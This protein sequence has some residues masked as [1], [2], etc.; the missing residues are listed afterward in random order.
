MGRVFSM[1]GNVIELAEDGLRF[2][3]LL[4]REGKS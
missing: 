1:F 4:G 3:K 2:E